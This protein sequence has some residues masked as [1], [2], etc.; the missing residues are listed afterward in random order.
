MRAKKITR[1]EV[2]RAIYKKFENLMDCAKAIKMPPENFY[3]RMRTLSNK[4]IAKLER[5]GVDVTGSSDFMEE[6]ERLRE[7]NIQLKAEIYDL[8]RKHKL[9][10]S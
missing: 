7:E 3:N 1:D 8:R 9:N 6:L 4:F 2:E 5:A 10:Q